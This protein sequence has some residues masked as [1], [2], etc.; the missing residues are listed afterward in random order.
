MKSKPEIVVIGA[1]IVDL[2][3]YP[4]GRDV[5]DRASSPVERMA[6]TVGGDAINEATILTRLGH[7]VRLVSAVGQDPAGSFVL[8]HCRKNKI[9]SSFLA[10]S[11][12][13][14]TS[15]NVPLISPD[16]ERSVITNRSGSLWQLCLDDLDLSC[17][18]EGSVL[19]FA[20]IFNNPRL[21][22]PAMLE[23]FRRAKE[24]GMT[25]CADM[26]SPRFAEKVD[27]I[28]QALAYVDYFFPNYDEACELTG[29]MELDEIADSFLACGVKNV[30]IKIG[31]RGAY[32]KNAQ[33]CF[34]VPIY[35]KANCV[36]T[37]GAG[38]NFASGFI[39]ALLEGRSLRQC[40]E[41]ANVTASIAIEAVG[42][43]T[44]L[45]SRAQADERY[46]KYR[47]FYL[48]EAQ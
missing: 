26:V 33:E 24:R 29:L 35:P 12:T 22:Q 43:T 20:S 3:L 6:M 39:T 21:D 13:L 5:F 23:I 48:G 40:A 8:E 31:R 45:Q 4:V 38:D 19:S 1:A 27:D 7:T 25:I 36:D 15:I 37:T 28:R 30:I 46:E 32:V 18:E 14:T 44:A 2:P 16:G 10:V 47:N 9:D 17:L 34:I 42:A 41:F 11:G